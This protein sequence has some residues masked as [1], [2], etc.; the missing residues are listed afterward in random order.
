MFALYNDSISADR[1]GF[2][3]FQGFGELK[4]EDWRI[5]GGLQIDIFAP[6]LPT[7]LPFSFLAASGNAGI[8]RGQFRV[9]RFLYPAAD[10]Q[11]T[12]TAGVS[13]ANPTLLND[14]VLSED[15]GWPNVEVRAAWAVGAPQQVGLAPVRPFEVGLSGV[16]GEIRSTVLAPLARVVADVWGVAADYRWRVSDIWG[17]AGEVFTGDGLG[18]YGG[19]VLQNVNTTTF[20]AIE[21]TGGWSEVYVYLTPCVH[22]HLG[23]GIDDPRDSDLDVAQVARNETVFA[24]VIWD[25]TQSF[26]LGFEATYRETDYL[27][28]P[29]N[30]GVGFHGQMQWKF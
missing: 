7:V 6:V 5:A 14:D 12:L 29:D 23:Y 13:D 22:T 15:N 18:T 21:S 24:N 20:L 30:D 26:R 4:N 17:F 10:E 25:V 3:P 19:G 2:L 16:V 9:E 1:Y 8:Y 27:V 28:L 11:V